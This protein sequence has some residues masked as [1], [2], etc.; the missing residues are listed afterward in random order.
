LPL[1][2]LVVRFV[3]PLRTGRG[4]GGGRAALDMSKPSQMMLQ[5]GLMDF[6]KKIVKHSLIA[7]VV[8]C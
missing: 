1:F 2:Q 7:L 8:P 4:G 6:T 5:V 3:T